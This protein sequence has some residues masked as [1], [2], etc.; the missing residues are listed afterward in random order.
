MRIGKLSAKNF[1]MNDIKA[2]WPSSFTSYSLP[3]AC[4]CLFSQKIEFC[5]VRSKKK[6]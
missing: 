2:Y 1:E 6:G 3:S 4:V 5:L